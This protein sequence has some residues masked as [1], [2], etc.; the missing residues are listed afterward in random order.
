V[1]KKQDQLAAAA[2]SIA[3]SPWLWIGAGS[4]AAIAIIAIV[5]SGGSEEN[6]TQNTSL[7]EPPDFPE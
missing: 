1:R 5:A 6:G 3:M 2:T 4:A 7:P